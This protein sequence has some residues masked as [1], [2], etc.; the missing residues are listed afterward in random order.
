MRKIPYEL[1]RLGALVYIVVYIG[2]RFPQPTRWKERL[3]LK[4]HPRSYP[5][6]RTFYPQWVKGSDFRYFNTL[7][8]WG[9][10]N[11]FKSETESIEARAATIHSR[12]EWCGGKM[13]IFILSRVREILNPIMVA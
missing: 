2:F 1:S 3:D 7:S 12:A 6:S 10:V 5:V 13:E 4:S 8:E 11:A 9:Q